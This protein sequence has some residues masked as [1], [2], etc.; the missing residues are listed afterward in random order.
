M[1][2]DLLTGQSDADDLVERADALQEVTLNVLPGGI[3]V[4]GVDQHSRTVLILDVLAIEPWSPEARGG[5]RRAAVGE[6][7]PWRTE[8]AETEE[9]VGEETV[10]SSD[11]PVA[12]SPRPLDR[13][14]GLFTK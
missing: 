10:A 8:E 11:R 13:L 12:P 1:L 5:R 4:A 7:A 9:A 3:E 14:K 6:S 2:R